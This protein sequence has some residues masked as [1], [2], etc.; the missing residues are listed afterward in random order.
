MERVAYA[1]IGDD[2]TPNLFGSGHEG[3]STS[4]LREDLDDPHHEH[5]QS[6]HEHFYPGSGRP[7][8]NDPMSCFGG[9]YGVDSG[10]N[11]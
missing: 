3:V 10:Y 6:T 4:T 5:T 7:L 2:D 9:L 8:A 1:D 11:G